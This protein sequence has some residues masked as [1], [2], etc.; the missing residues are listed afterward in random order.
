[1]NGF[2]GVGNLLRFQLRRDRIFLPVWV[3]AIV[4]VV[5]ASLGAIRELYDTPAAIAGYANTVASSPAS[6][7]LAGPPFAMDQIG[8]ILIYETSLTALLGVALMA[9]FTVVRHTRR[10]ED[11]GRVELLG[12][13]VVSPHAVLASAVLV[14]AGASLA[15]GAGVAGVFLVEEQP[16]NESLLYGASIAALGLVFTGVAAAASQ[17]MSHARGAVGASLG[18]LAVAY[19]LRAVGDLEENFLTWRRRWAGRS[20]WRSTSTTAGGRSPCP[21]G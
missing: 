1:M 15:V 16:L 3:L 12:S 19:G 4:A 7:A 18:F 11:A 13:T 9:V 2:T 8:G 6:V 20:R 10:E 5:Y 14:A 17:L 21:P